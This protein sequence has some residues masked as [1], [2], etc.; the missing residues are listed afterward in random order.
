[1][2][3]VR[4]SEGRITAVKPSLGHG[5][6]AIA[7]DHHDQLK[8]EAQAM[9]L[10]RRAN[11]AHPLLHGARFANVGKRS[12]GSGTKEFNELLNDLRRG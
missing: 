5:R 11:A 3:V 12:D 7:R 1:M 10:M 8:R 4:S 6:I 9:A 2:T